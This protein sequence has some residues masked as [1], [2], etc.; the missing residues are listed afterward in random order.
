MRHIWT[1]DKENPAELLWRYF[2]TERFLDALEGGSLYFPSAR[3][4]TDKFEGA[5]AI[6]PYDWPVDPRFGEHDM[7][8][9]AF[10]QLRRLTKI[11]CW[12][13]SDYESDAMWKL[14][15]IKGKGISVCST[16]EQLQTSLRPFRLALN[17]G[18]EEPFGGSVRYVDLF[19]QR[20]PVN[21]LERFFYKHRAFEWERE[22]RVVI[23]VRGAEEYGVSVPEDGIYVP[24]DAATLI[25]R[26]Y[27][28]PE[29][30]ERERVQ[31]LRRCEEANVAGRIVNSTLRGKP[32]YI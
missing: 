2:T 29:M 10:E 17:Y 1:E 22:Y 21:M 27:I 12:H 19:E 13:R 6:Q 24:F 23:S 20:L 28:G 14:Y 9:F 31:L 18:E 15:A 26:I 11:S 4:F 16:I 30:N 8:E 32:R 25:R 7:F 5:T 3:Q